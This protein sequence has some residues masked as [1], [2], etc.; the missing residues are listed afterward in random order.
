MVFWKSFGKELSRMNKDFNLPPINSAAEFTD[1]LLMNNQDLI[2][3]G[4]PVVL[5]IDEFDK[6]YSAKSEVRDSFLGA[7]RNIKQKKS[8]YCLHSLVC[9]GPFSILELTGTS[10][11]PF[12]VRDAVQSPYWTLEEVAALFHQFEE[13]RQLNLGS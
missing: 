5:F 6:L 12:N 9:I 1:I 11:S 13:E 2:F 10:A 3:K 7:F 4:K 8:K